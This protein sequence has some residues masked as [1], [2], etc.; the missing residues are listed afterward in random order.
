[1]TTRVRARYADGVLTPLKPLE[2]VD[3]CEVVVTVDGGVTE[4]QSGAPE[5]QP[6]SEAAGPRLLAMVDELQ[7]KYPP[8]TRGEHPPDFVRN[9]KHY[10]YGHPK[11]AG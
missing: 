3:G 10:L 9:K 5:M 1:M 6:Q 7:R 2:L 11:E 4:A 8:E